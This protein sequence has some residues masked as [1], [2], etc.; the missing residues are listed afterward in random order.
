MRRLRAA[1]N[2]LFPDKLPAVPPLAR[3]DD[4]GIFCVE[5]MKRELI[6]PYPLSHDRP[7]TSL[8]REEYVAYLDHS[9][10]EDPP[11]NYR[12]L[13]FGTDEPKVL[14]QEYPPRV[15]YQVIQLNPSARD[16]GLRTKGGGVCVGRDG[17]VRDFGRRYRGHDLEFL[18]QLSEEY[19]FPK[20]EAA[21]P[22]Q[23]VPYD[24]PWVWPEP[25]YLFF[26]GYPLCFFGTPIDVEE[27]FIYLGW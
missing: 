17:G 3:A 24:E 23:M 8:S 22:Q 10:V 19:S 21:P 27:P 16:P 12:L 13:V 11:R 18:M 1:S 4:G 15:K 6:L 5:R 14:R 26:T 9:I 20:L 2:L 7:E 25:S